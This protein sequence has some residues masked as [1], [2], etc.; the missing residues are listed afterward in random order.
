MSEL[1]D[2]AYWMAL[3]HLPYWRTERINTLLVE[4]LHKQQL[5]LDDFFQCSEQE[6]QQEFQLS[7]QEAGD[8]ATAKSSLPKLATLAAELLEKEFELIPIDTKNY[9]E[10]LKKNLKLKYAPSLLYVKGNSSLLQESSAAIV[11][12]RTASEISL[13]FTAKIAK[14]CVENYHVVVSG[15]AKGVD[16][17]ALESALTCGGK[18]IIVLPQGILKFSSG[19]KRYYEQILAGDLL[20]LSAFPPQVPWDVKWAMT[21]NRYIYGLAEVIYVAESNASGGT[22]SGAI[23]GLKKGRKVYVRQSGK[24]EKN[25]NNLLIQKG[26]IPLDFDGNLLSTDAVRTTEFEAIMSDNDRI[27]EVEINIKTLLANTSKPLSAK[28][29]KEK[30]FLDVDTRKFSQQLKYIDG[31]SVVR[32]QSGLTF[33]LENTTEFQQDFFK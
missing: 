20:V 16:R 19:F 9:S 5:A 8:V 6:W 14:K 12:A 1:Q 31:I 4:I 21:R 26:A 17:T 3:A 11:G 25:A 18:S 27:E 29:I 22:W 23:D 33:T 28:Q 7:S 30:L 32:Q 15:F 2:A 10:L 24:K 13:Q